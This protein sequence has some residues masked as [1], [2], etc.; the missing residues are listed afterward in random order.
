MGFSFPF[1][2]VGTS[3]NLLCFSYTLYYCLSM[4]SNTAAGQR[5]SWYTHALTYPGAPRAGIAASGGPLYIIARVIGPPDSSR[6]ELPGSVVVTGVAEEAEP[7]ALDSTAVV[8]G[9]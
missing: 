5:L 1:R 2:N 4:F 9:P 6:A 8:D 7:L 3:L